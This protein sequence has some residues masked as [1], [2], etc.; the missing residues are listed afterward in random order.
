MK[1]SKRVYFSKTELINYLHQGRKKTSADIDAEA[2]AFLS[3]RKGK[4]VD[5]VNIP[6]T[7]LNTIATVRAKLRR[8]Q[9]KHRFCLI[10][11]ALKQ[12]IK[13]SYNLLRSMFIDVEAGD[14]TIRLK[15]KFK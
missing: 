15:I 13:Y 14:I 7:S 1:R 9:F 5:V 3:S 8:V 6:S 2:D 4:E 12:G 10:L 11:Y